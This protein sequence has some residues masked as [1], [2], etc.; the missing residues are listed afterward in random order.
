MRK[1]QLVYFVYEISNKRKFYILVFGRKVYYDFFCNQCFIENFCSFFQQIFLLN[2]IHFNVYLVKHF[3]RAYMK[4]FSYRKLAKSIYELPALQKK[5]L[6]KTILLALNSILFRTS[7]LFL[8]F[9]I[10]FYSIPMS[11]PHLSML[12]IFP[13][14]LFIF[15]FILSSIY[16]YFRYISRGTSIILNSIK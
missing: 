6:N 16:I 13:F 3:H 12:D 7:A 14:L 5:K 8:Y 4:S 9:Y 1:N 2:K 10:P 15:F 11:F